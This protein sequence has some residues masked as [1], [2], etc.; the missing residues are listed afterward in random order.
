MPNAQVRQWIYGVVTAVLAVLVVYKIVDAD[1]VPLW[2]TL[3]VQAAEERL[4]EIGPCLTGCSATPP[5]PG[6]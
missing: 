3:A 4:A 5:T 2:L 6:Y 1:A